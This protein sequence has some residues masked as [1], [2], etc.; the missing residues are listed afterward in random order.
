MRTVRPSNGMCLKESVRLEPGVY[1]LP[2]GISVGAD[3]VE[4]DAEGV[5]LIGAGK[6][7]AAVTIDGMRGVAI[8]HL[9]ARDYY[10]GIK[11]TNCDAL[12]V[13]HCNVT[14]TAEIAPNTVFLDI[15]L[16]AHNPY[17]SALCLVDCSGCEIER[18]EFRHQMNGMLLYGCKGLRV[19]GNDCSYN[20]GFGIHLYSTCDSTFE[21]NCCDYCCRFEPREGGLHFGHM[22]ADATGFLAVMGSS[23]NKFIRNKARM[24]GDG[25]F[26]AGLSPEMQPCGCDDNLFEENDASLSPNIAFESTFCK[27]NI[28]RRNF[29]DR[30]NY[31]FWCG[32]SKGFVIEDN[33]MLFNR[34]AGIGVENGAEFEVR[35]NQFQAN[36]HG[37]LLWSRSVADFESA[38]PDRDTCRDWLIEHNSFIRNG[39]GIR[40]ASGQDHGIRDLDEPA[41]P[42]HSNTITHNNIQ[43]NRIGIELVRTRG[44]KIRENT[45]NAN[46]EV[47]LRLDDADDNEI[48]NNI[49]SR[50]AYL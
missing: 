20:S 8:R 39:V 10:H 38:Y 7:G 28:Y 42:V 36:G 9:A 47:N 41:V 25:F 29:A 45:L 34:Q 12:I 6:A 48:A 50:G 27:R 4:V 14:A 22:G 16:S 37:A 17:G 11:A 33:R 2:N 49:G 19:F 21:D 3:G 26:L 24:G 15:W 44:N 5:T 13:K 35:R 1:F 31:G 40:I 30:C 32:Y 46:V 18:N 23:C 43:D